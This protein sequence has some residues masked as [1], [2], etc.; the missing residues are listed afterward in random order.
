[1]SR[2][3]PWP[4][5]GQSTGGVFARLYARERRTAVGQLITLGSAYRMVERDR[6]SV[7]AQV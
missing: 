4:L 6:N 7:P 1:V 5:I 2:A 3:R